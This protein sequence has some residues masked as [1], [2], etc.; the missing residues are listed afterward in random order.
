MVADVGCLV[1]VFEIYILYF[2]EKASEKY[3][4]LFI[5][6]ID[7]GKSDENCSGG[8]VGWKSV[9]VRPD[10]YDCRERD[11]EKLMAIL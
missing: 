9:I 3:I 5:T 2:M 4:K 11:L 6:F 7:L 8:S 10:V 1:L